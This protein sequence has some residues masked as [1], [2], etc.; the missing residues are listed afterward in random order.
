MNSIILSAIWG[1][2]MMFSGVFVKSKTTVKY[3]A[4]FGIVASF[5]VNAMELDM[6]GWGQ[7]YLNVN[8]NGMLVTSGYSLAFLAV[9]FLATIIYFLLNGDDIQKVG[10]HIGEYYSLIFFVLCGAIFSSFFISIKHL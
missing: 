8:S 10:E 7:I 5:F 3:L 4:I 1:V 2:V 9:L 6:F